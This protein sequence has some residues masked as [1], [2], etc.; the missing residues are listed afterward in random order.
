MAGHTRSA[1]LAGGGTAPVDTPTRRATS[2]AVEAVEAAAPA[3][4]TGARGTQAT[5]AQVNVTA[6]RLRARM[7]ATAVASPPQRLAS[8]A[9]PACNIL[10][11]PK[12]AR[13]EWLSR[14]M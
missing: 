14:Q 13:L 6:R 2:K 1:R 4:A 12:A 3:A 5:T 11:R 10:S 8:R 9:G 7:T